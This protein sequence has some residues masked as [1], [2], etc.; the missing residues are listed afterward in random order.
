MR[1]PDVNPDVTLDCPEC[2]GIGKVTCHLC[3][4]H[5][6]SLFEQFVC[7][8]CRDKGERECEACGGGGEGRDE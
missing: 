2:E 4:G 7:S 3:S 1:T 5:G 8:A 6:S